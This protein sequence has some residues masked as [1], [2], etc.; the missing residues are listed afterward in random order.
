MRAPQA[1]KPVDD[2]WADVGVMLDAFR[3]WT[4]AGRIDLP[5]PTLYIE[6]DAGRRLDG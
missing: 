1:D 4:R 5:S 6:G 3:T 2:E